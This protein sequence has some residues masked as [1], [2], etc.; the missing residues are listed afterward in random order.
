MD[1]LTFSQMLCSRLCHDLIT[2][3]GAVRSGFEILEDCNE[4]ERDNLIDMTRRSTETALR[5]LTFYRAA[6]GYAPGSQYPTVMALKQLIESFL[7]GLK[8]HF[9]WPEAQ[10]MEEDKTWHDNLASWG[11][12]LMNIILLGAEGMP[13]GGD[14]Q[15]VTVMGRGPLS[16]AQHSLHLRI[17]FKGD[18][19]TIR[20]PILDALEGTLPHQNYTP[21]T[22][23]ALL[24]KNLANQLNVS[25]LTK[26]AHNQ[27]F[28]LDIVTA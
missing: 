22:I 15:L 3:M 13:Y 25:L 4:S 1:A 9:E 19:V 16:A 8:I 17:H 23:Q 21:Q 6:F 5:R 14:I 28:E 20:P 27:E 11:Q 10:K 7:R 26:P 2:P 18:L 12:L 24:V